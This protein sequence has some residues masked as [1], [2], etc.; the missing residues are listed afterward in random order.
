MFQEY[1]VT[2]VI[3]RAGISP[4]PGNWILERSTDGKLFKPWQYFAVTDEECWTQYGILASPASP[5]FVSDSDVICTAHF[6]RLKPLEG[7]EVSSFI[8]LYRDLLRYLIS[9]RGRNIWSTCTKDF[10]MNFMYC[11]SDSHLLSDG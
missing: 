6:S 4:R 8:Y 2:Y 3:M 10:C 7:G 9:E 1:Q 11:I 5:M